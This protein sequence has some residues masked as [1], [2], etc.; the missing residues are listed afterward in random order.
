MNQQQTKFMRKQIRNVAQENLT[1]IMKNEVATAAFQDVMKEVTIRLNTIHAE[2]LAQLKKID[3]RQADIQTFM[4]NQIQS[5]L[6]P[7]N[8]ATPEEVKGE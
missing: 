3:D 1:D 7:Q 5:A 4:M 8:T 2:V 6:A